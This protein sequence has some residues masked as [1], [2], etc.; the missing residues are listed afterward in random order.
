MP[1]ETRNDHYLMHLLESDQT[2]EP[3]F[4]PVS[5]ESPVIPSEDIEEQLEQDHHGG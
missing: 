5:M 1:Y 3:K 4:K 2:Q